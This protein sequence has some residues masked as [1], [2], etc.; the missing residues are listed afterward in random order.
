MTRRLRLLYSFPDGIGR[1]GIG[2]TAY[3][4]VR[5][6]AR[7]GVEV[8]LYCTSQ[9]RELPGNVRVV[10]TL[11]VRGRRIPHRA[12][13]VKRAYRYHDRRV[14]VA[15]RQLG[16]DI[17][18]V[19]TWPRAAAHTARAA[20]RLGIAS[21]REVP[22]THTAHAVE[23]VAAE[24]E[25]LGLASERAYSH[26]LDAAA[27]AREEEEYALASILLVPSEYA[28]ETFLD[29][30]VDPGKLVLHRYGYEPERFPIAVD[31]NAA[32][33]GRPFTVA[34]VGRCEPRKGLHYALRAWLDSGAGDAGRFVVCGSFV[35]GYRELLDPLLAHPSV[36]LLGYVSDPS[37]LMRE[38]D[39]FVLPSVEEGSALVTYEAQASGCVLAVSAAAGARC[40]HDVEGLVHAPRD[41]PA[42]TEHLR[43]LRTDPQLLQ[44]L[45][46]ATLARA[47]EL[48]WAAAAEELVELYAQQARA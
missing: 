32:R 7:L 2:T 10:E 19:H 36:E 18:V 47:P 41:L 43:S 26:D 42:L 6:V 45:R 23:A 37:N 3:H 33:D 46:T 13:G 9:H 38:S 14:A 4:Q 22:N 1:P 5:E 28:R 30:G 12:L 17:D 16:S 27:I 29:R 35:P 44:R 31:T 39:V 25:Q 15:L 48:T 11:A 40:R 21:F 34:F 8:T 24:L 20:S